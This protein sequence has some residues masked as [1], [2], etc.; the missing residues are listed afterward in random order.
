MNNPVLGVGGEPNLTDLEIEEK[1][2]Q[3]ILSALTGEEKNFM[4]DKTLHFADCIFA[5][6]S[7]LAVMRFVELF[8]L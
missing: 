4:N 8:S 7:E 3:A 5:P 2:V 6:K 1:G